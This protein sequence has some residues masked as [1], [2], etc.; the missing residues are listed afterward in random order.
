MTTLIV[1]APPMVAAFFQG[2][3]RQ[4]TAYSALGQLD[5][6][7]SRKIVPAITIGLRHPAT[8]PPAPCRHAQRRVDWFTIRL[9][10]PLREG[11]PRPAP[12]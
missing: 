6:S 11:G 7:A 8:R 1:T 5:L 10:D 3:L 2:T 4:F 9:Q 12:A